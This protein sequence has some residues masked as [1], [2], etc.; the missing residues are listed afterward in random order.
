MSVVTLII[1]NYERGDTHNNWIMSVE[2][3]F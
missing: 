1:M 3:N 2:C